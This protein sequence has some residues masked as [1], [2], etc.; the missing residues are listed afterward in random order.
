MDLVDW[1]VSRGYFDE[2]L[3]LVNDDAVGFYH[4]AFRTVPILHDGRYSLIHI[5][6]QDEDTRTFLRDVSCSTKTFMLFS[7]RLGSENVSTG[8]SAGG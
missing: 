6:D 1:F 4:C 8:Q 5:Q 2:F 7:R 3:G